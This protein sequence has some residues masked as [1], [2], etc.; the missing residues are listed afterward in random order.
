M[1]DV[2]EM[3]SVFGFDATSLSIED[4]SSIMKSFDLTSTVTTTDVESFMRAA[5]IDPAIYSPDV[6]VEAIN[7][8]L[9]D[10]EI[11]TEAVWV[12]TLY[13]LMNLSSLNVT[14]DELKKF[15]ASKNLNSLNLNFDDLKE[16]L[17]QAGQD[18]SVE[19]LVD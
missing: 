6:I 12:D 19:G 2:L 7:A 15:L 5:G 14:L 1:D 3:L 11:D 4:L 8:F 13:E 10:G 18:L 9:T 16:L 17:L